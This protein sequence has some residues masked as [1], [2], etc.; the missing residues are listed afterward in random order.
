MTLAAHVGLWQRSADLSSQAAH[1]VVLWL[2][3]QLIC[4]VSSLMME[5]WLNTIHISFL[6]PEVKCPI[7]SSYL[8]FIIR[9]GEL[10]L[11]CRGGGEVGTLASW[12]NLKR[13]CHEVL[14][15]NFGSINYP[16]RAFDWHAEVFS[17]MTPISRRYS[18]RKLT[19]LTPQCHWRSGVKNLALDNLIFKTW[20][21]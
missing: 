15:P 6:M 18:N 1:V 10:N 5:C 17:N 9:T 21:F 3:D 4:Q 13:Q 11:G 7:Y 12:R 8:P 14:S 2:R 16:I 20:Y 19:F